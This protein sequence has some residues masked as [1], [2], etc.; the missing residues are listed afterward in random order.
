MVKKNSKRFVAAMYSIDTSKRFDKDL[1][2]CIKRGLNIQLV[3]DAIVLLRTTGSLPAKY[4]PHKLSG[5][6]DGIWECHIQ[7]NWLM[8]WLQNDQQLTLLFL[9]TGTHA[10][11]F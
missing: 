9:R 7:P 8:T 5:D 3:Y 4:K 1:K 10:D 2:R 6:M 11:L